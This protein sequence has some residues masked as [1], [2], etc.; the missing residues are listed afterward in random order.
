MDL[1]SIKLNIDERPEDLY[2]RLLAFFQDNLVTVGGGITHHGDAPAVYENMT[3]SLENT[4]VCLWLQ[5]IHPG[6]P[7]L[8]KQK[9]GAELRNKTLASLRLEI[10]AALDALIEELHTA[11]ETRVL[12]TFTRPFRNFR[13]KQ[14]Q[15]KACT[16]CRAAGR[17]SYTSHYINKCKFLHAPDRLA[18]ARSRLA[19]DVIDYTSLADPENVQEE[20]EQNDLYFDTPDAR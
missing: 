3:Q 13:T 4:V 10:S 15:T 1:A 19:Q 5:L 2:Q 7:S 6:L 18:T 11:E 9:Y 20:A 16:L 8:V 14:P 17:P 12:R